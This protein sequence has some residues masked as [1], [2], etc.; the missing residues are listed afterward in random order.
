MSRGDDQFPLRMPPGLRGRLK[1]RAVQ[2]RRSMNSELLLAIE[3]WLAG[4]DVTAGAKFGDRSP[5]VTTET[6][7]CQGGNPNNS[8]EGTA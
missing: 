3:S 2:S 1:E 6:A 4:E 8:S 5:A 7:A